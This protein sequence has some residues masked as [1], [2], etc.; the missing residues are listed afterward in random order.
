MTH[1]FQLGVKP[2]E[3]WIVFSLQKL[4]ATN[5]NLNELNRLVTS[6]TFVWVYGRPKAC[7][8][9]TFKNHNWNKCL[10]EISSRIYQSR[11]QSWYSLICIISYQIYK[12]MNI[13]NDISYIF[14]RKNINRVNSFIKF[15]LLS[16]M[17]LINVKLV[18]DFDTRPFWYSWLCILAI[19]C[20]SNYISSY[21]ET[22]KAW[23][24]FIFEGNTRKN[25]TKLFLMLYTLLE[26]L[27]EISQE[28]FTLNLIIVA[29]I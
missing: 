11:Y 22:S 24:S 15:K 17:P 1:Y 2:N 12:S 28:T 5:T 18:S 25:L 14:W 9:R 23:A 8:E 6:T 21:S 13:M 16:N 10:R 27:A 19:T 7:F 20:L 26:P 29:I 3:W 4:L